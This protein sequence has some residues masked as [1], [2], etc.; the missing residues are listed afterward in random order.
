MQPTLLLIASAHRGW[1]RLR[2]VLRKCPD[3][4]LV[5]EVHDAEQAVSAVARLQPAAVLVDAD[6]PGR[7]FVLLIQE[8]HAA[9]PTGKIIVVGDEMSLQRT[10]LLE[11]GP[12]VAAYLVWADLRPETV[13]HCLPVVVEDNLVVGSRA[14]LQVHLASLGRQRWLQEQ[15]VV[16][17]ERQRAILAGLAAGL[18]HD[19]IGRATY[20]ST[21]TV[22]REI[23]ALQE[24]LGASS[25]FTLGMR[26]AQLGFV[27]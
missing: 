8:L 2:P 21:R 16:L 27:S 1:R 6:I 11:L 24:K 23:S 5:G 9:S 19:E 22:D 20:C 4:H 10:T 3:L 14:V 26:A 17:T 15:D 12:L 13:S 25:E 7:P 18:G